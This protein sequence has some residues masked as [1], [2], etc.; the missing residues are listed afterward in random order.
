MVS[1]RLHISG[2]TPALTAADVQSRFS[3]FGTVTDISGF[4]NLD[5]VGNPKKFAYLTL[6]ATEDKLRRCLSSLSGTVWKGAKLRVGDAKPDYK[7]RYG[8]LSS[9]VAFQDILYRIQKEQKAAE[10]L[11]D[12]RPRKRARKSRAV[13]GTHSN[14]MDLVSSSNASQRGAWKLDPLSQTLLRP[15]RLRPTRPIDVLPSSSAKFKRKRGQRRDPRPNIRK[16]DPSLWGNM[17][18][19][20]GDLVSSIGHPMIPIHIIP[21]DSASTSSASADTTRVT[22]ESGASNK[23]AREQTQRVGLSDGVLHPK[24]AAPSTAENDA[25]GTDS[26]GATP[27]LMD[28][29]ISLEKEKL[30]ALSLLHSMFGDGEE[31]GGKEIIES[32]DDELICESSTHAKDIDGAASA[33]T[34]EEILREEPVQAVI[35]EG[36][37]NDEPDAA[38]RNN[39]KAQKSSLKDMFKPQETEGENIET[40]A[41]T[42]LMDHPSGILSNERL[43]S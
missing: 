41:T 11:S 27:N 24:L 6:D 16:I 17:H 22:R 13:V 31:W 36:I 34:T 29:D 40:R 25:K 8:G 19:R 37:E 23:K 7:E 26:P 2:L 20:E 14:S 35:T 10:E 42:S 32:D 30:H 33:P 5:A 28:V 18:L 43:G 1:K 39:A 15:M 4:G 12:I 9:N 3:V 38:S 21:A